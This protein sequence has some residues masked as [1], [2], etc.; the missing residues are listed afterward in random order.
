MSFKEL[1]P[2]FKEVFNLVDESCRELNAPLYLIGAQARHFHLA[3]KG[4]KP[5]RETM[6]IDYALML[7]DMDIYEQLLRSLLK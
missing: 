5:S 6:D 7:P 4:I 3:E 1:T 2:W